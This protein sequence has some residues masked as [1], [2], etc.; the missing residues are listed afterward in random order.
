[1]GRGNRTNK[2]VAANDAGSSRTSTEQ[3]FE[4]YVKTYTPEGPGDFDISNEKTGLT[5]EEAACVAED[6]AYDTTV[7]DDFSTPDDYRNDAR[8]DL[9][10]GRIYEVVI[11]PEAS[12]MIQPENF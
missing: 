8:S 6:A 4:A 2:V 7:P 10:K 11:S 3:T 12:V 9:R 5:L 1:M